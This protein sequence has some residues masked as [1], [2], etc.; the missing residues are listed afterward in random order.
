MKKNRN[1]AADISNRNKGTKGTN[2]TNS[3][4]NGNRGKQLNP[5]QTKQTNQKSLFSGINKFG[6]DWE[7]Y[8]AFNY[9]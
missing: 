9:D 8:Y 6:M 4:A 5:N 7:A 3:K 2:R 1:H